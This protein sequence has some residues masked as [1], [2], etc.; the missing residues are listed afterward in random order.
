MF[1]SHSINKKR[2]EQHQRIYVGK[3]IYEN[4]LIIDVIGLAKDMAPFLTVT[5]L[6]WIQWHL[7]LM[8]NWFIHLI[9]ISEWPQHLD[10]YNNKLYKPELGRDVKSLYFKCRIVLSRHLTSMGL[11]SNYYHFKYHSH[12]LKIFYTCNKTFLHLKTQKNHKW[13]I[14]SFYILINMTY[15]WTHHKSYRCTERQFMASLKYVL[16]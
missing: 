10:S 3:R 2:G 1:I 16:T 4:N 6:F 8:T 13:L 9:L 5:Q 15:M 7:F 14:W 11:W 12:Q